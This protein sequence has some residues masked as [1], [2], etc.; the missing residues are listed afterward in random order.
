[1]ISVRIKNALIRNCTFRL[2]EF[3]TTTRIRHE[4][5]WILITLCTNATTLAWNIY[6]SIL[7]HCVR[8][9]ILF[10]HLTHLHYRTIRTIPKAILNFMLKFKIVE[11][12][13]SNISTALF[14]VKL[15]TLCIFTI[16]SLPITRMTKTLTNCVILYI[17]T[18]IIKLR[19]ATKFIPRTSYIYYAIFLI[20]KTITVYSLS[21]CTYRISL[22]NFW[23]LNHRASTIGRVTCTF[24]WW[25]TC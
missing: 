6:P 10:I 25:I 14:C 23:S 7:H 1:M 3:L 9:A 11:I 8:V 21:W 12:I 13:N 18:F 20:V 19:L 24:I 4:R 16:I 15:K 22:N 5:H 2:R 17:S